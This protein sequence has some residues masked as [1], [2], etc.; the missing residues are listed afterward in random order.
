MLGRMNPAAAIRAG[1]DDDASN[2]RPGADYVGTYYVGRAFGVSS[3]ATAKLQPAQFQHNAQFSAVTRSYLIINIFS[4]L[5]FYL[6]TL[7]YASISLNHLT[8]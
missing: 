1:N 7:A 8:Y 5:L 2:E 4:Y 3:R 6:V